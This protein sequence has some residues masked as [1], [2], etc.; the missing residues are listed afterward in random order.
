MPILPTGSETNQRYIPDTE[1]ITKDLSFYKL[2]WTL[3]AESGHSTTANAATYA[4]RH[5]R[6]LERVQESLDNV[7]RYIGTTA[8]VLKIVDNSADI[9]VPTSATAIG[10]TAVSYNIAFEGVIFKVGTGTNGFLTNSDGSGGAN[11]AKVQIAVP[12]TVPTADSVLV[13]VTVTPD[14]TWE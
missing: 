13:D 5:A 4:S 14:A 8:S 7:L 12:A 1:N 10:T 2:T 9:A 3:P 11:S 6:Q